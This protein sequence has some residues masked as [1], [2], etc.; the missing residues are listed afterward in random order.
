MKTRNG[1]E[2]RG[3]EG[4]R[5]WLRSLKRQAGTTE[6]ALHNKKGRLNDAEQEHEEKATN[7][8]AADASDETGAKR[9]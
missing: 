8:C 4:E 1:G 6:E 9:R 5:T 3:W 7:D 2:E